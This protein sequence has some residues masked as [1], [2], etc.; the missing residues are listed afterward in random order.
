MNQDGLEN[1]FGR[2]RSC[3]NSSSLI[4]THFRAT[5][6][7]VFVNNLKSSHSIKSN[8]EEDLSTPLLTEVQELFLNDDDDANE[9]ENECGLNDENGDDMEIDGYVY[10]YDPIIT[11]LKYSE[12][13]MKL[14]D[15]AIPNVSSSVCNKMFEVIKCE[16]CRKT[17]ETSY[18]LNDSKINSDSDITLK[19]PSV[20]F[21]D[22]VK[23]VFSFIKFVLPRI[24]EE[25]RLKEKLIKY[26]DNVK[27]IEMGCPKHHAGVEFIFKE[28]SSMYA[29]LLFCKNV[30]HFLCG[31]NV[32]LPPDCNEIEEKAH[33]FYNKKQNIGKHSDIF[34]FQ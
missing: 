24:C 31:K 13:E 25:K 10:D 22:N 9:R 16:K 4:A 20:L 3:C 14:D 6:A 7:T 32:T 19:H 18:D 5:Y 34:K 2:M 23:S 15:D 17:L 21:V 29:I 30:N 26:L 28:R 33:T 11:D 8:C 1:F 27:I 12:Q